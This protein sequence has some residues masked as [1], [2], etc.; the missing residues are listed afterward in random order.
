MWQLLVC[1]GG[2][3]AG[4]L[5]GCWYVLVTLLWARLENQCKAI[6]GIELSRFVWLARSSAV[7]V[8]G[9]RWVLGAGC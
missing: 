3:A 4:V 8:A 7:D 2:E 5:L 9:L 6:L 1:W